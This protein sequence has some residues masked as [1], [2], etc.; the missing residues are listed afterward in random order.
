M[1]R[2]I[3]KIALQRG[4]GRHPTN[5][6]KRMA[7]TSIKIRIISRKTTT[8]KGILGLMLSVPDLVW[9]RPLFVAI[10]VKRGK[11]NLSGAKNWEKRDSFSILSKKAVDY[12]VTMKAIMQVP[13]RN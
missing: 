7:S 11:T 6:S 4:N 10:S 13:R 12:A 5:L 3:Y 2:A 9:R 8:Q 1:E